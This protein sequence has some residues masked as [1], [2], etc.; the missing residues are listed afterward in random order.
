MFLCFLFLIE[1]EHFSF[2]D[3]L[4]THP[5][6]AALHISLLLSAWLVHLLRHSIIQQDYIE[7]L[8]SIKLCSRCCKCKMN[9]SFLMPLFYS[10]HKLCL[11]F[12]ATLSPSS[13]CIL[14]I[15]FRSVI[16]KLVQCFANVLLHLKCQSFRV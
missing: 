10:H 7:H 8:P 9:K 16:C 4:K 2:G 13:L 3:L 1:V 11:P 5:N 14:N 6:I 15:L 12:R